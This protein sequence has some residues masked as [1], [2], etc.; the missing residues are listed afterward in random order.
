MMKLFYRHSA[1]VLFIST[2][3]LM[4][5]LCLF[6]LRYNDIIYVQPYEG[7]MMTLL[8]LGMGSTLLAILWAIGFSYNYLNDIWKYGRKIPASPFN[9]RKLL[10]RITP[11]RKKL[12]TFC[13]LFIVIA[14]ILALFADNRNNQASAIYPSYLLYASDCANGYYLNGDGRC[15]HHVSNS[16]D[17]ASA[18]C[19][20]GS[21]S[22]STHR[23]GTCSG[24]KGVSNWLK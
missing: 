10:H 9:T 3:A 7:I 22:Y 13:L 19:R 23:R 2:M 8:L 14:P 16:A 6:I 5:E 1:R 17:G 11:Y 21:Y 12:I 15:V 4:V 18:K 20:D 24:H